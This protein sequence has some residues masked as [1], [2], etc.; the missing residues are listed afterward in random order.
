MNGVADADERAARSALMW[1][2]GREIR[3]ALR[4]LGRSPGF[5]ASAWV[6]LAVGI[7]A[8]TAVFSVVY[9]V[10]LKPLNYRAPE[11][12]VVALN[13]TSPLSPAD[14]FDYRAQTTSFSYMGAAQA[15]GGAI[16]SRDRTEMTPGL[17]V[18]AG[19]LGM[20]GVTPE[21]GRVFRE[22]ED[23]AGAAPVIV[24]SHGVWQRQLGGDPNIIG[25]VLR[26]EGHPYTVVG[27]MP[28]S[29]QF[30]PF[31]FTEAQMWT[32]LDLTNRRHDRDGRSLRVFARLKDGVTVQK[33]QAEMSTVARRLEQQYPASNTGVGV[34]VIPLLAKVT[35]PIRPTLLVLLA[36]VFFVLLIACAN[37]A[38]LLL[39]RALGR[40]REMAVRLAIGASRWH[41]LR[42]L[43]TES[44]LVSVAGGIA[45]MVMASWSLTLLA[46]ILPAASL[47]RMGEIEMDPMVMAFAVAASVITGLVCGLLPA[48]ESSRL[49]LTESLKEGSRGSAGG[50]QPRARGV[51]IA[52]EVS[53][54]LVLLVCA[55]LMIRTLSELNAV[56]PGFRARGLLTMS[57]YAPP[58][59]D[60]GEKRIAFFERVNRALAA[61]NGIRQVS[62]INHL[63]ISGDVWTFDYQ[64]LGRPAA[65]PG[66]EPSAVYRVIRP[67]YFEAMGIRLVRGR[68][69]SE[70]DNTQSAPVV[71]VSE[72]LARH[73]WPGGDAVGATLVVP[74]V[75]SGSAQGK[76]A[77]QRFTVVGVAGN[78]RQSDWTGEPD[79]EFY[80]PYLQHA[81]AWDQEHETF[82]ARTD[83]DPMAIATAAEQSVRGVSP[84]VAVSGVLPMERI[85]GD[86]LWRSRL[87]ALLL[88][89]FAGIALLLAAVGIYG[90]ISYSVRQRRQEIGIR[91]ALGA[92]RVQLL[93]MAL[94]ES[95]GAVLVGIAVG[96]GLAVAAT[97][98]LATLLY[99]VA[100]TDI[101][102]FSAVIVGMLCVAGAAALIPTWRAVNSDALVV[103]RQE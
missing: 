84:H 51:L 89:A 68:G 78:T 11:R 24:I 93:G 21:R 88:G 98:W 90:V 74:N 22:R 71:V 14:F 96:V 28:A 97:R 39:T 58:G 4:A 27:V 5:T 33:A 43:A 55:G 7:G 3:Q 77:P 41:L 63:P 87:S 67:G 9:N 61:T 94:S 17:Q 54:A 15:W 42:Q 52:A 62:A 45:G 8:N 38:N 76:T 18:S 32:P 69:F 82:V 19:L 50:R 83:G 65:A 85:I 53:L 103:L 23:E 101:P 6:V 59:T 1:Q 64:V 31:W 80:L 36:T 72:R 66:H 91:M 16:D 46:R 40:R 81:D 56:E 12:L 79:E 48:L 37:I 13:Q 25:R 86:K 75:P 100:P 35:G 20:L 30:A 34:V 92:G 99:G 26:V 102:T 57:V 70:H 10:L 47:P 29:F 2:I 73:Q 95:M 44:L 60:T 49:D